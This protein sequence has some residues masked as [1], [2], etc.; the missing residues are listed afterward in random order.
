[1]VL[2]FITPSKTVLESDQFAAVCVDK[3]NPSLQIVT[4]SIVGLGGTADS[5]MGKSLLVTASNGCHC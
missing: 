1:M 2:S 3:S 5:P 4:A